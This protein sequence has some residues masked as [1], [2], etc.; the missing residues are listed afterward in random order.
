M[1]VGSTNGMV[2]VKLS[3]LGQPSSMT[4]TIKGSYSLSGLVSMQLPEGSVVHVAFDKLTGQLLLST[5]GQT[6]S[7]GTGFRLR[8]H[9]TSGS[10]GLLLS[11]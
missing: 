11:K 1:D 5:G 9:S 8:R 7:M 10:N 6:F 4:I 2:R 3:S